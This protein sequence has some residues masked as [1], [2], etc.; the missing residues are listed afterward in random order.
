MASNIFLF[1]NSWY[2][3]HQRTSHY[4][5]K[6]DANR[7]IQDKCYLRNLLLCVNHLKLGFSKHSFSFVGGQGLC[8]TN[9]IIL[10]YNFLESNS[11]EWFLLSETCVDPFQQPSGRIWSFY[12]SHGHIKVLEHCWNLIAFPFLTDV[13]NVC[14][15]LAKPL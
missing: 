4:W 6:G 11:F 8:L 7:A 1:C 10:L 12:I 2:L 5:R 9:A 14:L 15:R 3:S 13:I